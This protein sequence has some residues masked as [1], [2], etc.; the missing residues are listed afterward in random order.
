MGWE[1]KTLGRKAFEAFV[2]EQ[3]LGGA[4]IELVPNPNAASQVKGE[5]QPLRLAEFRHPSWGRSVRM[6]VEEVLVVGDKDCDGTSI[7]SIVVYPKGR[8]PSV[9]S[10]VT[11]KA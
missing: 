3:Q 7:I 11:L 1:H 6:M 9:R 4:S 10:A 2:R 8:R 5:E